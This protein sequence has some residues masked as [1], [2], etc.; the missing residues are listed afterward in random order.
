MLKITSL[1]KSYISGKYIL[2]DINF[3][4]TFP[5]KYVIEGPNGS[6][7]STLIGIIGGYLNKDS[8]T[9]EI[10]QK[11]QNNI[12]DTTCINNYIDIVSP[13]IDY[14]EEL[15][16]KEIVELLYINEKE[17]IP[18]LLTKLQFDAKLKYKNLSSGM[19]QKFKILTGL[20]SNKPIVIFDEPCIF[21]DN[22]GEKWFFEEINKLNKLIIFTESKK[23]HEDKKIT[24]KKYI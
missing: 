23:L 16:L 3:E 21:L 13:Y 12:I 7:K 5:K 17:L 11:Q 4:F 2:K 6:G 18:I 15:N 8:G 1:F 20:I 10:T 24:I 14:P 9:I 22:T 19:K